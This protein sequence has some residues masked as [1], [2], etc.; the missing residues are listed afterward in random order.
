MKVGDYL[1]LTKIIKCTGD[2]DGY[3]FGDIGKVVR[4]NSFGPIVWRKEIK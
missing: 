4:F 1:K 2:D 3:F